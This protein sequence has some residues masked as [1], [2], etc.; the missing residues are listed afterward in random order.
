EPVDV[1]IAA[2][3]VRASARDERLDPGGRV[4]E[5]PAAALDQP[6]ELLLGISLEEGR[7]LDGAELHS[8]ADGVQVVDD[9]LA[10][11][12]E[13]SIEAIPGAAAAR[14][15]GPGEG[16]SRLVR[17]VGV[18]SRLPVELETRRDDAPGDLRIAQRLRL[19]DG[20]PV[21]REV[22]GEPHAPIVP[23]RLRVPLIR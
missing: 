17:V 1:G 2:I 9:G 7:A 18:S 12:G 4:A 3:D 23:R 5:G 22:R 20:L 16:L 6:L 10:P 15:P 11:V 21:D 19:V 14:I 8:D 13:R